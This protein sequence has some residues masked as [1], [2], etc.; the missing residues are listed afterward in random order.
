MSDLFISYS[1]ADRP[2]V[3]RLAKA[4]SDE[5]WSV[6]WD[7]EIPAG[8]RFANVIQ[9]KLDTASCVLAIWSRSSIDSD[10]VL[11]EASKGLDRD[12]LVPVS[13]DDAEIPMPFDRVQTVSLAGWTGDVRDADYRKLVRSIAEK[14][15]QEA[16]PEPAPPRGLWARL[17]ARARALLIAAGALLFT[18]SGWLAWRVLGPP[19]GMVRVAGGEFRMGTPRES[20]Q[21]F[22]R[23]P[24]NNSRYRIH[25]T[26]ET[27]EVRVSQELFYI[28]KY[29]VTWAQYREHLGDRY[30]EFQWRD[31]QA[32][33]DHPVVG[34]NWHEAQKYCKEQGKSLPTEAQWEKAAR[35]V[36]ARTFP[37]GDEIPEG[38]L[39]NYCDQGCAGDWR[40]SVYND[41]H[42]ELAPVGSYPAGR[43]PYGVF[44]LAGNAA[45]WVLDEFDE[46]AYEDWN[47]PKPVAN[48][49]KEPAA[50][51]TAKERVFRGGSFLSDLWELRSAR[52]ATLGPKDR[53][54]RVGFRCVSEIE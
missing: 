7:Q 54:R 40:D 16:P 49:K 17:S 45:E 20:A 23:D 30:R 36:D 53:D 5:S 46:D 39:A 6:W 22:N 37:W 35:G 25:M 10:W 14:L 34:V 52:R 29:E 13:L 8:R 48:P 12:V 26:W 3:E 18:V 51:S 50:G 21:Y 43:S 2:T 1:S 4:L 9:R 19:P 11:S 44:D 38:S 32:G 31:K 28:D 33:D 41:G 42:A 47:L 27:P 24:A 15:E